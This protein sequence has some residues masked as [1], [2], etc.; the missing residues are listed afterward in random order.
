MLIAFV[1]LYLVVTVAIGLWAA[2]RVGSTKDYV[3]AGRSVPLYMST[4]LVF[5]TWFGAETVLGVSATFLKEGMSGIVADPF[6][7][8]FCLVIVALFFARA[9]YRL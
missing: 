7:F 9:F 4:A 5:A 8:S 6:G 1:G 3:V 2:R